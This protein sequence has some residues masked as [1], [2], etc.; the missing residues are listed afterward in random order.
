MLFTFSRLDSCRLR[1]DELLFNQTSNMFG[2]RVLTH[3][4]R[5]ANSAIAG[6]T[7]EGS[8]VLA[9]HQVGVDQNLTGA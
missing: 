7:L 9:V 8:S 5:F 6:M 1:V 3:T 2:D 4:N